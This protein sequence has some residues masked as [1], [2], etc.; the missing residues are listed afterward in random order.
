VILIRYNQRMTALTIFL[1]EEI[2]YKFKALLDN[3]YRVE[4]TS[5]EEPNKGL[6]WKNNELCYKTDDKQ[7]IK[8]DWPAQWSYHAFKNY[9]VKKELL[10]KALGI[11]KFGT[12]L[13]WDATCGTGKDT[14]LMLAYGL[15]LHSFERQDTVSSL[16]YSAIFSSQKSEGLTS[17]LSERFEFSNCTVL[18]YIKS[19]QDINWPD[20]LYF[21]PMFTDA[22][23]KKKA[24]SRKEM[25]IFKEVVGDDEDS[26]HFLKSLLE[27]PIKRVVVKRHPGSPK[28]LEGVTA[29]FEGKSVRYDLYCNTSI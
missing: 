16:I 29:S 6:I 15:K 22:G 17:V 21:D 3:N 1:A 23:R 2:D 13:V 11:S 7:S 25:Q 9:S 5:A 14:L 4:Y 10:A 19:N 18:D 20:A 24:L 12:K 8:F 26:A 28:L 27:L